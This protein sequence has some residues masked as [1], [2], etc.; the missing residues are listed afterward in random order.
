MFEL[1]FLSVHRPLFP[2]T[3]EGFLLSTNSATTHHSDVIPSSNDDP[4][5]K[6]THNLGPSLFP[7][8]L[9]TNTTP[10]SL[11]H[12]TPGT[13][14]HLDPHDQ[15]LDPHDQHLDSHNQHLDPRD[16]HLDPHDHHLDPHDQHLDP[17]D[18][19]LD[20]HDHHLDPHD[21][22]LDPHDHLLDPHAHQCHL[23]PSCEGSIT[24]F[25]PQPPLVTVCDVGGGA[26]D[27]SHHGITDLD[28]SF[29]LTKSLVSFSSYTMTTP[30]TESMLSVGTIDSTDGGYEDDLMASVSAPNLNCHDLSGPEEEEEEVTLEDDSYQVRRNRATSSP[31]EMAGSNQNLPQEGGA[32]VD[33]HTPIPPHVSPP[34]SKDRRHR[35]SQSASVAELT[36][37]QSGV[38]PA[39]Y[40][41]TNGLPGLQDNPYS[42]E[43]KMSADNVTPRTPSPAGSDYTSDDKGEGLGTSDGRLD[44]PRKHHSSGDLMVTNIDDYHENSQ[45]ESSD[46]DD[47]YLRPHPLTSTLPPDHVRAPTL[48]TTATQSIAEHLEEVE[49]EVEGREKGDILGENSYSSFEAGDLGGKA[50]CHGDDIVGLSDVDVDMKTDKEVGLVLNHLDISKEKQEVSPLIERRNLRNNSSTLQPLSNAVVVPVI[51]ALR[52]LISSGE[53]QDAPPT[54]PAKQGLERHGS[55]LSD[56]YIYNNHRPQPE[57]NLSE[58]DVS[59]LDYRTLSPHV[60]LSPL[61]V[62]QKSSLGSTGSVEPVEPSAIHQKKYST[63]TPVHIESGHQ[64]LRLTLSDEKSNVTVTSTHTS[65]EITVGDNRSKLP[66]VPAQ[67]VLIQPTSS[68][69]LLSPSLSPSPPP[70]ESPPPPPPLSKERIPGVSSEVKSSPQVDSVPARKRKGQ[71]EFRPVGQPLSRDDSHTLD[72]ESSLDRER[73]GRPTRPQSAARSS[74]GSKTFDVAVEQHLSPEAYLQRSESL[75]VAGNAGRISALRRDSDASRSKAFKPL[76]PAEEMPHPRTLDAIREPPL[77]TPTGTPKPPAISLSNDSEGEA[78]EE[79]LSVAGLRMDLPELALPE[80]AWYKTINKQTMR[81][82]KKEERERQEIIH[83]LAV[84]Q[85]HHVRVL[86]LLSIVFRDQLSKCLTDDIVRDLFPGLDALLAA[87]KAFDARLDRKRSAC[88]MVDDISDVLLEQLTGEGREELLKAYSTFCSFHMNALEVFKEQM[89]KKNI[90]RLLKKL[91]ALEECQRLTL[92][93]FYQSI[94]QH[95]TKLVPVMHRLTKKT[96]AL[97]LPHIARL[98]ECTEKFLDLVSSVDRAVSDHENYMELLG[99]QN[100]LEVVLPK[101]LKN[102][103]HLKGLSLVAHNRRLRKQGDAVWMGNGKQM[104]MCVWLHGVC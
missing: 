70:A 59:N 92:P 23:G 77:D 27:D 99:I 7:S 68:S 80:P 104:G 33:S 53:G 41:P 11:D 25:T 75:Q 79:P 22:H 72:Q 87:S 28:D 71:V 85:K 21:Q 57:H 4:R 52:Y 5:I 102:Y 89:R 78:P 36:S 37:I 103:S 93:D 49:E 24:S 34:H 14:H 1:F 8:S 67:N 17:H 20:P 45:Y 39:S 61:T 83:E 48:I 31:V 46:E 16:Q 86:N 66:C 32:S 64:P 54:V 40:N 100:R 88:S 26:D 74:R 60:G 63:P 2:T 30:M 65:Q 35:R 12:N 6:V 82:M 15:H 94:S 55:T 50:S 47:V 62:D 13:N 42:S 3:S 43:E 58:H 44:R 95:L 73:S 18:H 38:G 29:T 101:S 90:S 84:T 81:K 9:G 69:P 51:N 76:N 98:K 97:K 91:H 10:S 19:H 96:E 56:S